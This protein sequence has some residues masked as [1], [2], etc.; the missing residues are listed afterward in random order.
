MTSR[1]IQTTKNPIEQKEDLD[2]LKSLLKNSEF[3]TIEID[4]QIEKTLRKSTVPE[5]LEQKTEKLK[6]EYSV[7]L[8]YVP[9]IEILKRR[10]E[11]HKI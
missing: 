7:C 3:P 1:I 6:M 4:Q 5:N 9:G 8:P 11:K 2:K 10:L